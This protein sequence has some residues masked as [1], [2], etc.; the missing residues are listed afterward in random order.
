M[1]NQSLYIFF[2]KMV[3]YALRLV[4]PYFL[5]RLLTVADFGSYRQFFLLEMYFDALFQLGLNQALY[6]FIPRDMRNAGAYFLN[7]V[8]MNL[9]VFAVAFVLMGTLSGPLSSWLKMSILRTGFW[10]LVPYVT[11]QML[12][13]ACDAYLNSRQSVRAAAFFEIAGQLMVSIACVA[14]AIVSRDLHS[15]LMALVVARACHLAGM[16]G[17]IH[18]KLHGLRAERYFVGLGE[19]IRY[20]VVLGLGGTLMT[21]LTRL[22]DFVV[23]HYYGTESYAIYSAG[24]TELPVI[25][26]FTQSVAVVVLGQ[27]ALLEQKKDWEGTRQLWRRVQ[28]S[29]YAVAVPIT[30]LL[31]VL[32]KPIILFMFT[33]KY[34]AAVPIFQLN[35][36]LKLGLIFNATLVLR[37]LSRNDLTIKVNAVAFVLS[38]PL[39]YAGMKLGGMVGIIAAQA[40]LVIG[41]RL[42]A[43]AVMNRMLEAPLPYFVGF[44]DILGFYHE[45]WVKG[46][47]MLR[48]FRAGRGAAAPGVK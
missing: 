39:L 6:Y 13:A 37:A 7:T 16:A 47:A 14:T 26:L 21:Q 29:S 44:R 38:V 31:V 22:H 19:Q 17:F 4:L 42:A 40:V 8:L 27:F 23:S 24:C 1:L 45:S 46:L 43:V 2:A 15:V 30:I 9:C 33:E 5:V 3:G 12:V 11:F 10:L 41:S 36:I 28:T 34:A 35:S 48:A 18:F 20:G 25:Q 32:A